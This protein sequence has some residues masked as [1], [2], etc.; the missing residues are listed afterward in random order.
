[1]NKKEIEEL[2]VVVK[3]IINYLRNNFHP[4]TAIIIEYDGVRVVEDVMYTPIEDK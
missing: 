3:P 4:F 2:K 1:M